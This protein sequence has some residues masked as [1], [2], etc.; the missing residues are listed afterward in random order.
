MSKNVK[1]AWQRCLMDF[2]GYLKL[3][4]HL[5]ANSVE[6]YQHDVMLLMNFA[7]ERDLMPE[8]VQRDDIQALLS[9]LNETDIAITSQARFL[10]GWRT[11]YHMLVLN[12]YVDENPA[13]LIDMP[14]RKQHLPDVLT[15]EEIVAIQSTMDI[16]RPDQARNYV[17]V[18]VLYGC[19]LRV[20]ELTEMK[21]SAVYAD[22]EYLLVTG[23]GAKQRWVPINRRALQLLMDYLL[24]V[25]S[26]IIPQRGE[27]N[28]VF[29]N[30]RGH[31][32]TRMFIYKFLKQAADMAG[33]RKN[34]SP[35]TL[36]HSFATELV[37][38]GADLRAVQ[39][40]L[41]HSSITTTEIYTHLSPSY[42]RQ[43]IE[44]YHPHYR[45]S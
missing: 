15:D 12:D 42:L 32:L 25:R 37:Q 5:S 33:I 4:R 7:T 23:K 14:R 11:F 22:E 9:E 40:M 31:H 34:I 35:H 20:S 30:R 16:S 43:T 6:A 24:N 27:E 36:R 45:K 17:I 18:E 10:S 8:A 3:E 28:Y 21:L 1:E 39:E 29:L 41:G 38:N 26:L 44:T 2:E 19:G 13:E